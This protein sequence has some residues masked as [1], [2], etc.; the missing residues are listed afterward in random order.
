MPLLPE[1]G[2]QRTLALAAF[3]NT[4]GTGLFVTSSALFFTRSVG[5][6]VSQVELGL[7]IAALAGLTVGIPA[8]RIH[9]ILSRLRPKGIVPPV[10]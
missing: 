4:A 3:I 6:P 1:P 9:Q 8:G 5:L 10:T 7:T 2:P